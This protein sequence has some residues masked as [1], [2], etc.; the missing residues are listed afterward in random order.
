MRVISPETSLATPRDEA[1]Y[2]ASP[3]SWG[4]RD[5]KNSTSQEEMDLKIGKGKYLQRSK[6]MFKIVNRI[7]NQMTLQFN[8][9]NYLD[10]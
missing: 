10:F 7:F 8:I 3:N 2:K 5:D 9:E 6:L 4:Q 1:T